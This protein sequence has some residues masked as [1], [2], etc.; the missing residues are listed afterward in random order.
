MELL[1]ELRALIVRHADGGIRRGILDGVSIAAIGQTTDPTA[2]VSEPSLTIVAQGTKRTMLGMTSYDYTEG[3]YV[4]TSVALPLTSFVM[5]ASEELP[6]VVVSIALRPAAIAGLLL[7]LD[8]TARPIGFSGLVVSDAPDELLD[9]VVRLVRLL[10]RPADVAALAPGI[11]RE[12]LWRLLTGD[13][14]AIV[15]QIGIAD[16]SLAQVTRAIRWLRERYAEPVLVD[17]LARLAGMSP[18]AFHRHFRAATSMS[19]IQFQKQLRLNEAR[20][21]LIAAAEDVANVGYSVGYGSP[22]QFSREY[23][24]RFGR[25]PALDASA[26]R[27]AGGLA[28][29]VP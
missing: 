27:A 18:A 22:S 10:D 8:S 12:I 17:D 16:G 5:E 29:S 19:P 7:D 26:L 6:F 13:Q 20:R 2:S 1:D 15:R 24:R 9:P 25:P 21:L 23:R 11:E 3:Q 28:P 14:A 4:V